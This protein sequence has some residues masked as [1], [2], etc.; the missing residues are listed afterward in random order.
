MIN[1][2]FAATTDR[3]ECYEAPLHEALGGLKLDYVLATDLPPAEVDYI[4]YAP[5]SQVQ[6]FTPYSRLKAVM[7]L[8][9]GVEDVVNNP[10]LQVPLAR[11]VDKE[12]LTQGMVE[13]V[14]GHVLRHHLG[15]DAHICN[16]KRE[17]RPVAPPLAPA[18]PV[19]ILGLGT[20]GQA[21]AHAL[22]SLG[23]P[24]RAWSRSAKDLPDITCHHGEE[25][26]GE[27]LRDAQ[28]VIL[29]LPDT[30]ATRGIIAARELALVAPGAVLLNP[31]R[32]PLV[33]D[34]AVIDA[35]DQGQLSHATLDTF[36]IDN[37]SC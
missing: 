32:G 28:I 17:W 22:T 18:R 13:W 1:I 4:I 20:L 23:F 7:N 11:M 2:L 16:P 37:V 8:W 3:W 14:T 6:D 26:L 30:A 15:M 27:A 24:V 9:A 19:T 21:C 10:T 35:L 12:G 25:G 33:D 5:N 34:E 36:R 31:G 29:L